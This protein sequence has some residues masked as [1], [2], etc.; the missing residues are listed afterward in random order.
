MEPNFKKALETI[1]PASE[2]ELFVTRLR[3]MLVSTE[4]RP[5]VYGDGE[6]SGL[7]VTGPFTARLVPG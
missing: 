6:P 2:T 1:M 5:F 7:F 3:A 4:L